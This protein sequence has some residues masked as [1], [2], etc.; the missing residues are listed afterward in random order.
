M[1]GTLKGTDIN[2]QLLDQRQ[3]DSL[4][5]LSQESRLRI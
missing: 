2:V 3:V 4:T 1:L 5:T